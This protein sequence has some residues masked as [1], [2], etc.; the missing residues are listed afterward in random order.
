[1]A[2]PAVSR[3]SDIAREA[4]REHDLLPDFSP[5]ALAETKTL[6]HAAEP[7]GA[8]IRDLRNLPWVSI[9]ND[10][11]LDLDQLSVAGSDAAGDIA[12]VA[13]ADVDALVKI[14][15]PIDAHASA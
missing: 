11:S 8:A 10:D 15:S 1:M 12:C 9:D 7:S 2:S 5:E 3:L 6:A 13:V 4:M 14:A